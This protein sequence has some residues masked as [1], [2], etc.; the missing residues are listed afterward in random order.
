MVRRIVLWFRSGVLPMNAII[1]ICMA[2][3]LLN[4]LRVA[5]ALPM[6]QVAPQEPQQTPLVPGDA[7]RDVSQSDLEAALNQ[8]DVMLQAYGGVGAGQGQYS[9]LNVYN[10]VGRLYDG[11]GEYRQALQIYEQALAIEREAGDAAAESTSLNNM[12]DDYRA[13]G[14]YSTAI[15]LEQQALV[16]KRQVGD[17]SG[18]GDTLNN[19]GTVYQADGDYSH[20]LEMFQQALAI[21]Q[22]VGNR[23]HEGTTLGNIATVYTDLGEYTQSLQQEQLALAVRREVGDREGEAASLNDIGNDYSDLGQH[24]ESVVLY[25][26][27]LEIEQELGNP[28]GEAA[29]VNNIG[30]AYDKLGQYAQA[31]DHYQQA[32]SIARRLGDRAAEGRDL[33]NIADVYIEERQDSQALQL[34]QQALSIQRGVGD[35]LGE[36][37]TL[38]NIGYVY[39]DLAKHSQAIEQ[40]QQALAIDRDIGDQ[41]AEATTLFNIGFAYEEQGELSQALDWYEQSIS[42]EDTIRAAARLEE[43]KTSLAGRSARAYEYAIEILIRLNRPSDAFNL[44][45]HARARTFLDQVGNIHPDVHDAGAADQVQREQ[46]LRAQLAALDAQLRQERSK[47]DSERNPDLINSLTNQLANQQWEYEGVLTQLKLTD[48]EYASLVSVD[49]LS[50]DQVQSQLDDKTT[51]VSYFVADDNTLAFVVTAS[52]FHAVVL[53]ISRPDLTA[54]VGDVLQQMHDTA[55]L[56]MGPPAGLKDLYATLIGPLTG[57]VTTPVL[58]VIPHGVLQYLPFAALTDT[59]RYLGERYQLFE[60]PSASALPFASSKQA[61]GAPSVLA[62]AYAAPDGFPALQYADDEATSVASD[63]ATQPMLGDAASETVLKDTAGQYAILHV[64]AHGELDGAHPLFSRLV[65]APDDTNDGSVD[66]AEVYELDL[67]ET[68]LV[69]LSACDTQLGALGS[70]DDLVGLNRAFM[71]AGAPSVIASLWSVDDAS[72][73]TLMTSFYAHLRAGETKAEALQLA[74]ADTR[75]KYPDPYYWAAFVLTGDPGP[76]TGIGVDG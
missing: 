75:A 32:L 12:G 4:P 10:N 7:S 24:A 66:V 5:H 60:L 49:P 30:Y 76:L 23:A 38:N 70:G 74:E 21:E 9:L 36:A 39:A 72:T 68:Q 17:R 54:R 51:L 41:A 33:S 3:V 40:Y 28:D 57:Y 15:Q 58:G 53:P 1:P 52:D 71:Y 19:L 29:A 26:Q 69:V 61:S 27:A 62:L 37:A 47:P 13:L 64:V 48:P 16:I 63:F 14:Q 25:Q 59:Q 45:E 20:A 43:F 22:E 73:E 56:Q 35:R 67:A 46:A 31:L 18:E 42:V 34:H 6:A 55:G 11:R 50:L 8:L 2:A 65:L 44:S